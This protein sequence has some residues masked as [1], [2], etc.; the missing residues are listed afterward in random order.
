MPAETQLSTLQIL[1]LLQMYSVSNSYF[2]SED[3]SEA[4]FKRLKALYEDPM[5]EIY[6]LFYQAVLPIFTTFNKFLQREAPQIYL[7]QQQMQLLLS[8]LLLKFIN[9]AV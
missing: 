2:L 7:L 6:L 1:L 4:R 8:K 9:T 3:K 5:F